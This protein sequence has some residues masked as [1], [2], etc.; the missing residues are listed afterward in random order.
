MAERPNHSSDIE[1]SFWVDFGHGSWRVLDA[2]IPRKAI[3]PAYSDIKQMPPQMEYP[4]YRDRFIRPNDEQPQHDLPTIYDVAKHL[5]QEKP[6][7]SARNGFIQS[8]YEN[9]VDEHSSW[10]EIEEELTG[11]LDANPVSAVVNTEYLSRN[12]RVSTPVN[13]QL[14]DY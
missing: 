1:F 11:W 2:N 12:T 5:L 13:A 9:E 6:V 14:P 10:K 7:A 8:E 3:E 4:A